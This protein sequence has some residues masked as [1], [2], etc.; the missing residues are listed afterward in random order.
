MKTI[1]ICLAFFALCAVAVAQVAYDFVEK[2]TGTTNGPVLI[3]PYADVRI[4]GREYALRFSAVP[5]RWETNVIPSVH[6]VNA[7]LGEALGE[8]LPACGITT[9]DLERVVIFRESFVTN[10]ITLATRAVRLG[11]LLPLLGG[12]CDVTLLR[13]YESE[14]VVLMPN[15]LADGRGARVFGLFPGDY[16]AM[17]K[18]HGSFNRLLV[19][20]GVIKKENHALCDFQRNRSLLILYGSPN[21]IHQFGNVFSVMTIKREGRQQ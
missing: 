18:P 10:R 17:T 8:V 16:D 11:E 1:R 15:A 4:G 14:V 7:T 13:D 19:E 2:S 3:R 5:F 9:N 21:V 20:T 6:L 12:I